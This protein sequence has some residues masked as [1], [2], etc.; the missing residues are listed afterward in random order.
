MVP[1]TS[2]APIQRRMVVRM[3]EEELCAS[4]ILCEQRMVVVQET[5]GTSGSFFSFSTC[6]L[7]ITW[8]LRLKEPMASETLSLAC[9]QLAVLTCASFQFRCF[10][11]W[12]SETVCSPPGVLSVIIP[13]MLF[14]HSGSINFFVSDF[15]A[16]I[17]LQALEA[18]PL[19]RNVLRARMPTSPD[20]DALAEFL[21][22]GPDTGFPAKAPNVISVFLP[23]CGGPVSSYVPIISGGLNSS[24]YRTRAR[25]TTGASS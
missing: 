2:L 4:E 5:Q 19:F 3:Q 22:S 7:P 23:D 14:S 24:T 10:A 1:R 11:W 9:I 6:C 13:T 25:T 8:I 16:L 17:R 21:C 15:R 18:L 20:Y 12:F